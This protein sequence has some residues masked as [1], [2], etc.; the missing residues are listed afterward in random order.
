MS[1]QSKLVRF[2]QLA[3]KYQQRPGPRSLI[4]MLTEINDCIRTGDLEGA[5]EMTQ[6]CVELT[7]ITIIIKFETSAP[8]G[9]T[10]H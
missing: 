5:V 1:C 4:A 10:I 3:R 7:G 9:E 2:E 6:M 8:D